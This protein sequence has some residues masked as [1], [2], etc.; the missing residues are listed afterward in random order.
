MQGTER[1]IS[2]LSVKA[3]LFGMEAT[4]HVGGLS[5]CNVTEELNFKFCLIL[6]NLHVLKYIWDNMAMGFYFF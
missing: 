6:I 2:T 5:I 4:G 3:S 1:S